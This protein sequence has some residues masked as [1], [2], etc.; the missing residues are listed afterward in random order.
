MLLSQGEEDLDPSRSRLFQL[1]TD[2]AHLIGAHQA[3][4]VW[5]APAPEIFEDRPV[6]CNRVIAVDRY[7]DSGYRMQDAVSGLQRLP[8]ADNPSGRVFADLRLGA[9]AQD[10]KQAGYA[11]RY[12]PAGQFG[13]I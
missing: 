13:R 5:P 3:A 8:G 11:R 7:P 12:W 6:L 4:L 9:A 1:E 10:I 2:R